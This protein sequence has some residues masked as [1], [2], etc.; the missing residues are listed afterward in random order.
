MATPGNNGA[1]LNPTSLARRSWFKSLPTELLLAIIK[2]L[3]A[4]DNVRLALAYPEYFM[5]GRLNLFVVDAYYQLRLP[6]YQTDPIDPDEAPDPLIIDVIE[7]GTFTIDVIAH[8]LDFYEQ[9]CVEN[10]I[11]RHAFLNSTFPNLLANPNLSPPSDGAIMRSVP[12]T[13]HMA[14]LSERLNVVQYLIQR[15]ADVN[16]QSIIENRLLTPFGFALRLGSHWRRWFKQ[17]DTIEDI[18]L[19]L[20]YTS[21]DPAY[22]MANFRISHQISLALMAGMERVVLFFLNQFEASPDFASIRNNDQFLQQRSMDI[23]LALS[24]NRNV[25]PRVIKKML[26]HGARVISDSRSLTMVALHGRVIENA[27]AALQWEI[28]NKHGVYLRWSVRYI[29]RL[30]AH[31]KNFNT[32]TRLAQQFITAFDGYAQRRILWNTVI[33][34]QDAFRTRQWLLDNVQPEVLDGGLLRMAIRHR[35]ITTASAVINRMLERGESIDQ[36]LPRAVDPPVD[37]GAW[38]V[39]SYWAETPLTFA[40]VQENYHEAALLLNL[41][42]DPGLVPPNI[43]NRV[44]KIRDRLIA[45]IIDP[46]VLVYRSIPLPDGSVP[47]KTHAE[48]VLNYCFARLIFDPNYPVPHYVGTRRHMD[49]P[50]DAPDNDSVREDEP[51]ND[52]QI[53]AHYLLGHTFFNNNPY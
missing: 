20:A 41:G 53:Q 2:F 21:P 34:G 49:L 10:Q 38:E 37:P 40:L 45:G 5:S 48:E 36:R 14:I 46:K 30:A 47:T 28:E 29:S 18:I 26:E 1:S 25:I 31:D 17:R 52:T 8:I 6:V 12:T 35:D 13:L 27:V 16:R 43:R 22:N 7:N 19:E 39:L 50:Y 42:A 9:V 11:D 24:F 32:V 44:R 23:F 51:E 33:A 15:G 3:P 4:L